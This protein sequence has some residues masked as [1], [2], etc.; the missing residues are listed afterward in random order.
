MQRQQ[1]LSEETNLLAGKINATGTIDFSQGVLTSTARSLDV[2]LDGKG[3]IVLETPD[4]PLYTRDGALSINLL[5]QLVVSSGR[6]VAGQ[7]GPIAIPR[8]VS[9]S[10][11]EIDS[12]GT[13]RAG[14][15]PLGR[16]QIVDFGAAFDELIPAGHGCFRAPED[17]VPVPAENTK[18][19]QGAQEN[20]NVKM[21]QELTGLMT[22]SRLYEANINVMKKSRENT[23]SI[24]DVARS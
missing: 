11:I 17:L 7:N 13:M 4:G 21:M 15:I 5:G 18:L 2:A 10:D 3:F 23:S 14:E 20:S 19:R 12:D 22:L 9:E 24:L 8:A 1:R 6:L 16:I